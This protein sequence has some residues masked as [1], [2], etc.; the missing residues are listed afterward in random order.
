[1]E[2]IYMLTNKAI[3][4]EWENLIEE[5]KTSGLSKAKFCKQKGIKPARF[6][7]HESGKRKHETK[8]K[9]NLLSF[10]PVTI[11]KP[12]IFTNKDI[13]N[14]AGEF[15]RLILKNGIECQIPQDINKA[16]LKEIIEA[17]QQC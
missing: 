10:T 14:P 15:I 16:C 2:N 17:L 7:Y 3:K 11:K 13:N 9:K 12:E 4:A 6:Y 1:M 5:Q 8:N